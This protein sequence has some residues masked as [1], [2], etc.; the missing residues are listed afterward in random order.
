MLI[1]LKNWNADL[2]NHRPL[3]LGKIVL[4][5]LTSCVSDGK[6]ITVITIFQALSFFPISSY[7]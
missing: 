2:F 1:D 4:R 5:Q 7:E 6:G 3:L